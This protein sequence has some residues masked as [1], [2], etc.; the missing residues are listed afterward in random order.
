[1]APYLTSL[2]KELL[3]HYRTG[4]L[5]V[6]AAVLVLFGLTSPLLAKFTPELIAMIPE[7]EQFAGL[8]PEPSVADAVGQYLENISQFGLILA[9]LLTMGSVAQEKERGTAALMLVKPLP[10][11]AFLAAKFTALALIFA[12]SLA[13]AGL[14]AYY[15]TLLLFEPLSWGGWLAANGL[16]LLYLLVTVALTLLCSTLMR[17][18][19]AAGGLAFGL[20]LGLAIPGVVPQIARL[21]PAALVGWAGR[22]ALGPAGAEAGWAALWVSLGL[23]AAALAGAWLIFRR[24]EL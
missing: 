21:L 3:E 7:G 19:A 1:M 20:L 16:L 18:P 10:R 12:A 4:R 2:R 15:Y 9:L 17:T 13:L 5:L 8:I 11:G 14:G 23:V 22:V 24:Q 6:L